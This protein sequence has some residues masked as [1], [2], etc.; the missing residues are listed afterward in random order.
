MTQQ[1]YTMRVLTPDE[2]N[3]LTQAADLPAAERVLS[4]K[5]YLAATDS[6]EAWREITAAEAEEIRLEQ[7]REMEAQV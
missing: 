1:D 5:V 6:P 7:Q 3:Y 4:R 2:G